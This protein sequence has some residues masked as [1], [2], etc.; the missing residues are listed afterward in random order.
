VVRGETSA[1]GSVSMRQKFQ[2]G[3]RWPELELIAERGARSYSEASR[4]PRRA[5]RD[6]GETGVIRDP[7]G[8]SLDADL[9][10]AASA[11]PDLHE[12]SVER[13]VKIPMRDGTRLDATVWRPRAAG[14]YPVIIERVGYEL[15]GR[16]RTNAEDFAR[17][18]Y[19]FVGQNVRGIYAS[20]GEYDSVGAV[21]NASAAWWDGYD[22]IEWAADQAWSTGD[23]G[24]VD[25]SYS[26]WTQY[27]VAP[28]RPPH[29][30]ALFVRAGPGAT[31]L[32]PL[33]F[34]GGAFTLL[35]L[36]L[37]MRHVAQDCLWPGDESTPA[38][39]SGQAT[40]ATHT[41]LEQAIEDEDRWKR[42]LP[43]KACPPLQGIPQARWYFDRL[44]H[45]EDGPYWQAADLSHYQPEVD[46]P[47]FHLA[48]WFDLCLPSTL[49]AFQGIRAAG[50]TA[51]CRQSQRLLIGPWVHGPENVGQCQVGE[52]D[53]GPDAEFDLVAFRRRWYDYWLKH[54]ANGVM[55]GPVVQV[56]LMGANCW[57]DLPAWPPPDAAAT[58]MY[59]REGEGLTSA[60]LNTGELR[61][62]R[63][64][65]VERPDTFDYDPDDPVPSLIGLSLT[66]LGPRDFRP[67]EG[68]MLTYTSAPLENDL[69]VIG[70]VR[71]VLYGRS[72]APD[73]DWIVR[74]CDVHP[75]GRSMSVCDGILRARFRESFRQPQVMTPG[76]VYRFD[77]DLWATAQLFRAGHRLRVHVTSSDFP[78]YDRNLN[79]GGAFGEEVVGRVAVNS[80]LHDAQHPSHLLLPVFPAHALRAAT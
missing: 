43:L 5:A 18:G 24:M 62:E 12:V 30:R 77:V 47:I 4:Q 78:R 26:G 50:R 55:D 74:L 32:Y 68:R 66:D 49:G 17:H 21:D 37:V 29:L 15:M 27:L 73:T 61:F 34:R 7:K 69:T 64:A 72:S 46:V 80:V 16:C 23:V 44:A 8:A 45:P 53:F 1:C 35:W 58:P 56:F 13:A 33:I 79:T 40:V 22:T 41:R 57:V 76:Q 39:P 19:V 75:D 59:L 20:E 9:Q 52:L 42:H 60:S 70:P 10:T 71:A 63:P 54:E 65:A 31:G 48:G 38:I 2:A 51:R 36:G 11:S 25:G 6:E 28:T 67:V 14:R 3:R